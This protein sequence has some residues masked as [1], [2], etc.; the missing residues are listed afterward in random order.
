M[1]LKANVLEILIVF[2]VVI[3]MARKK[4]SG[5]RRSFLRRVRVSPSITLSTLASQTV[6][7]GALVGNS[8]AQYR[9]I[10]A[11]LNWALTG[12]T[13]AEGPVTVGYAFNDYTVT[14]VKECIEIGASI[15]PGDKIAQE[16]ANRWVRIVGTFEA[17]ANGVLNDGKPIKTRLNWPIQ[18]GSAVNLFAYNESANLLTTGAVVNAQGN[19]WVKDY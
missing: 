4:G 2:V 8:D 6:I 15:S 9:L 19:L 14:E 7:F 1:S 12:F 5:R 10:T 17:D 13:A 18:I 11:D 3:L 16:K